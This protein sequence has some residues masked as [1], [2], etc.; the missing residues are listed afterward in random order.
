MVRQQKGRF[1][2]GQSRFLTPALD[3]FGMNWW[4]WVA[5]QI[6]IVLPGNQG[7]IDN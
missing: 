6:K 1:I 7:K 4:V 3:C 2:W 5:Q